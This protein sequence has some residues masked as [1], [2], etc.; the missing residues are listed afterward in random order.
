MS[1]CYAQDRKLKANINLERAKEKVHACDHVSLTRALVLI[2]ALL[3]QQ[4]HRRLRIIMCLHLLGVSTSFAFQVTLSYHIDGV[5][6]GLS[7][8]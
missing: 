2:T 3:S 8:K 7:Q 4:F 1:D 5:L 6:T